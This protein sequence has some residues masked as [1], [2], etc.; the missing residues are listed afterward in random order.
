MEGLS[1]FLLIL[2]KIA[3]ADFASAYYPKTRTRTIQQNFAF[4]ERPSGDIYWATATIY[5]DENGFLTSAANTPAIPVK[6][7][8]DNVGTNADLRSVINASA[9]SA[10]P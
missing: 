9:K 3:R 7:R 10:T 1:E 2:Q 5:L 4:T 6:A 8:V